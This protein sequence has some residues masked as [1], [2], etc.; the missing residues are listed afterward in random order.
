MNGIPLAELIAILGTI[1]K[2]DLKIEP[3]W[4]DDPSYNWAEEAKARREAKKRE[5]KN[6]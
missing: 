2:N 6:E 1:A 4:R 3:T 5:G